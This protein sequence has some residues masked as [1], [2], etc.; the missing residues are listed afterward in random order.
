MLH[1]H[2]FADVLIALLLSLTL[3]GAVG[4]LPEPQPAVSSEHGATTVTA[5]LKAGP[6]IAEN[7][8][9]SAR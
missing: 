3:A 5:A 8:A 1:S 7:P 2:V 4:A 9:V 6:A